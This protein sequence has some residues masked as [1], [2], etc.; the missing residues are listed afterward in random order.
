[1]RERKGKHACSARCR[2]ALSHWRRRD[3]LAA[4]DRELRGLLKA[5]LGK[6]MEAGTW[7]QG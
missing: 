6:L 2:A 7:D 1:M 3:A 4:R 5:A